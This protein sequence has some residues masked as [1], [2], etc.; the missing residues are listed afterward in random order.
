MDSYRS[1]AVKPGRK[2]THRGGVVAE[3]HELR[4]PEEF[5]REAMELL[6]AGRSPRE[7]SESLHVPAD[8]SS[9]VARPSATLVSVTTGRLAKSARSC[10]AFAVRTPGCA[11]RFVRGSWE[12]HRPA[13]DDGACVVGAGPSF[14]RARAASQ[15]TMGTADLHRHRQPPAQPPAN[16]RGVHGVYL[17][18]VRASRCF[19]AEAM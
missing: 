2:V 9:G 19:F 15:T 17:A 3:G 8:A 1:T 6:L 13:R 16:A 14:D 5:R 11:R 12:R 18:Q 10:W 4:Y 7:L